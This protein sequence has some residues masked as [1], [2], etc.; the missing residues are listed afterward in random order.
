MSV[1]YACDSQMLRDKGF[2]DEL[3]KWGYDET[4]KVI[5]KACY[6]GAYKK[7]GE[8]YDILLA[9]EGDYALTPEYS[10]LFLNNKF[11]HIIFVSATLDAKK[12]KLAKQ[13][14]PI[15]YEKKIKEIEDKG[16]VNKANFF[17]VPYL[18]NQAENAEY[19]QYN[20]RFVKL[21]QEEPDA[22]TKANPELLEK[23]KARKQ[24]N[25]EF[26]N[27]SR[28]HFLAKLDSSAYICKK[29]LAYLDENY[30]EAKTLIFCG[31][32]EQAD[33]VCDYSYHGGNEKDN[34]LGL[35]DEGHIRKIS[36]CSKVNR[37]INIA[38]VSKMI[39][40]NYSKSETILVQRTGRGRRLSVDD[41]LD[42]YILV[43]YFKKWTRKGLTTVPT[44]MADWIKTAGRNLGI[45]N[46]KTIY[47]K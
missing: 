35:F 31:L 14:A 27:L 15:V 44:I 41:I 8:Y 43:P 20:E 28:I 5:E 38:G 2:S 21:I 24:K 22:R 16:V 47:L 29:L 9:D 6:A 32:T 25:L 12:R 23:W 11:G 36:V 13:I 46:A 19:I 34:N 1:L 33:R 17:M 30:P 39:L 45:E 42:V 3:K 10:K 4:D 7:E 37:G 40:E 18:L 26:L